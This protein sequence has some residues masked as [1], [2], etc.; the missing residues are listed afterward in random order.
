M[1]TKGLFLFLTGWMLLIVS[2]GTPKK[3]NV[4]NPDYKLE[5]EELL[6]YS[7]D[8]NTS[9]KKI[10]KLDLKYTEQLFNNNLREVKGA[11]LE[12]KQL[13][14]NLAFLKKDTVKIIIK[15]TVFLTK[16]DTVLKRTWLD[17]ILN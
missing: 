8:L 9:K 15:D 5:K 16:K 12:N 1:A 7:K 10:E 13:K 6:Q 11:L 2:L 14:E 17:K 4:V 3:V